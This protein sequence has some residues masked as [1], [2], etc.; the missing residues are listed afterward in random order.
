[1]FYANVFA[2]FGVEHLFQIHCYLSK[3]ILFK[4]NSPE[5]GAGAAQVS[6]RSHTGLHNLYNDHCSSFNDA[7]C[8]YVDVSWH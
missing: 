3:I 1:M 8:M 5:A 7:C 2:S 6:A 4:N